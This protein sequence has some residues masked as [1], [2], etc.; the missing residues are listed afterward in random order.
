MITDDRA[1]DQ[2]RDQHGGHTDLD[3]LRLGLTQRQTRPG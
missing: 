1:G 3:G 2:P